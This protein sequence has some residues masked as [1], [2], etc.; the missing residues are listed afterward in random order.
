MATTVELKPG[1]HHY[2]FL[3]DGEWRDDPNALFARKIL[4]AAKTCCGRWPER[5]CI[6]PHRHKSENLILASAPL[7]KHRR[8][9][10]DV[11]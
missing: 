11:F 6:R 8:D 1:T 7:K 3:V 10:E 4:T 2:R 9:V 5:H